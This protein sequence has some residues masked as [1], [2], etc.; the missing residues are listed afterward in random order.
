MHFSRKLPTLALTGPAA[1]NPQTKKTTAMRST[2]SLHLPANRPLGFSR[3]AAAIPTLLAILAPSQKSSAQSFP[4]T[5][6][7]VTYNIIGQP[8]LHKYYGR[9]NL[10]YYGSGDVT[11]NDTIDY[12][13]VEAINNGVVNWQ[14]DVN[15]DNVVN[16]VDAEIIS[17]YVS[18]ERTHLPGQ[19][20]VLTREEKR[21][22]ALKTFRNVYMREHERI[23]NN[24]GDSILW[25]PGWICSTY[26]RQANMEHFGVMD[27]EGYNS[28]VEY[29]EGK[30]LKHL[31][32][33]AKFNI[34]SYLVNLR[35]LYNEA[36][37]MRVYFIGNDLKFELGK[38]YDISN[39][40]FV[41]GQTGM[42]ADPGTTWMSNENN[43]L[44]IYLDGYFHYTFDG[45]DR[46]GDKGLFR[47]DLNNDTLTCTDLS[48]TLVSLMNDVVPK[49]EKQSDYVV[50]YDDF[51][52]RGLEALVLDSLPSNVYDNYDLAPTTEYSYLSQQT[53]SGVCSD[54]S[55]DIDVAF[56]AKNRFNNE[57]VNEYKIKVRDEVKPY[58]T[59]F[60]DDKHL[61]AEQVSGG[62][63][64]DV[65]GYA[66]SIDNS[67]VSSNN[68]EYIQTG[69][70]EN[71]RFYDV[72]ITASDLC[73][74]DSTRT[75]KLFIQKPSAV[76]P[77]LTED[78]CKIKIYPNPAE[79]FTNISFNDLKNSLVEYSVYS[80]SGQY[81][82]KFSTGLEN[83]RYEL[84]N[85]SPGMYII[86]ADAGVG[87]RDAGWLERR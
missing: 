28:W 35:T 86:K 25:Y 21:D 2:I 75:Q 26:A 67:G 24:N 36:H 5:P 79:S 80:S 61:T 48:P 47:Y 11:N 68:Y 70:S 59:S 37:T 85:L 41:D 82:D 69:E 55:F 73:G 56:K 34:P 32:N 39:F 78:K 33:V 66:I 49:Y 12:R 7:S 72:K 9:G 43:H 17:Q 31:E 23:P 8:N 14:G 57:N 64:P 71:E 83:F 42:E 62:L 50:S 10:E 81:I 76:I 58:F 65:T 1:G 3:I 20:N 4:V 60:P 52:N 6:D 27:I 84:S 13:D 22:W 30:E 29:G 38:S 53:S 40:L 54:F 51:K 18:G 74:N 46:F 45:G 77:T 44:Y 16:A 15:A 19:W 87:C 63:N